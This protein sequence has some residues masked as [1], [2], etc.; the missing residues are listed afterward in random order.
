[1][2]ARGGNFAAP[3]LWAELLVEDPAT[4]R[5]SVGRKRPRTMVL[6]ERDEGEESIGDLDVGGAAVAGRYHFDAYRNRG[7][8]RPLD[9]RID[10]DHVHEQDRRY[11]LH[12]LDRDGR[13]RTLRAAA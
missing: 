12:R 9:L 13:D 5:C 8:A 4:I 11:E 10:R 3:F 7:A 2:D 6:V 1:M